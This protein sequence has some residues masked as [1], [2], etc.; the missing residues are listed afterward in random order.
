MIAFNVALYIECMTLKFPNPNHFLILASVANTCKNI[1][2]LLASAS[3]ASINL[4]F[5][6]NNNMGDISGKAVSQFTATNMLGM[7]IGL[8]ISKVTEI[9]VLSNL[10]P[11]FG[12][13]SAFNVWTSYR[14]C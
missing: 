2:F 11:V 14:G 5:A 12:I 13:L 9:T 6:K 7:A 10:I 1:T 3:R 8:G 4:R